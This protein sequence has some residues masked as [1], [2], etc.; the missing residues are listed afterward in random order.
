VSEARRGALYAVLAYGAWGVIPLYW[1]SVG[2]IDPLVVLGQRVVWSAVFVALLL[3]ARGRLREA[4]RVLR[5]PRHLGVL[6]PSGLLIASNWAIF[7]WAVLSGELASASL[8]YFMNPLVNVVLGVALLGERLRPLAKLAVALAAAGAFVLVLAGGSLLVPLSLASTFAAY[9]Y[10][11]KRASVDSLI[12][13]FVETFLVLPLAAGYLVTTSTTY[14]V[15]DEPLLLASGVVTALPLL[16]FAAAARLLP[17]SRLGFFQYLAPTLQ[18]V[19]AVTLFGE[20]VAPN[21]FLAFGLVW[22]GIG[23]MTW[24]AL[25]ARLA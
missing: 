9:G 15:F 10:L 5:S 2:R 21:R 12:G 14:V 4:L 7:I 3:A 25:R 13:L 16:F 8:G 24:D 19:I 6:V 11:R 22:A 1:R 23:V 20:S 17:L 18:L